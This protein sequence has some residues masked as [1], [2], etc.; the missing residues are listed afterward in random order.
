MSA[1]LPP[2]LIC[3]TA[4]L[5]LVAGSAIAPAAW[6]TVDD[7]KPRRQKFGSSLKRL[8]WD[9][10]RQVT[11]EKPPSSKS[12]PPSQADEPIKL[13]TLLVVF[14]LLVVTRGTQQIVTGLKKE[15]FTITEAG[16]SEQVAT[17]ALGD[18]A[19][20]P[21]SIVLILD[22][23]ASQAPYLETSL[24]AARTLVDKLGPLDEMAILGDDVE[25][26]IDFTRDK[27]KLVATLDKIRK[28]ISEKRKQSRTLQFTTLFAALRELI[29]NKGGTRPIIIFQTDGDEAAAFRDQPDADRFAFLR[30]DKPLP[31]YGLSDIFLAAEKSR[32]TI[33]SVVTNDRL[34][35][36]PSSEFQ[37][38]A[39]Q[40]LTRRGFVRPGED[41]SEK[42]FLIKVFTE[43]FR[44]GQLATVRVA[45]LSGGWTAWLENPAQATQIY[46]QI[47]SD[48]NNRYIIGY[49]PT[50]S[51]RDGKLRNVTI[52]VKGHPEYQV[53]GRSSYYAPQP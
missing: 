6:V 41:P 32:A 18:D 10:A 2:S 38:R 29:D 36:I 19:A 26:L 27:A 21:K 12:E 45:S 1:R 50:D 34:I 31:E 51:A 53:H 16:R 48:I 14:D 47:L 20:R 33:Y 28:R 49:Y 4:G 7:K 24:E 25:L 9:P 43:V 17:F 13:E 15:D 37:Q 3:L 39:T 23:S 30:G 42:E 46:S 5:L 35:G 44:R 11:V 52:E 8:K 22:Y 40:L